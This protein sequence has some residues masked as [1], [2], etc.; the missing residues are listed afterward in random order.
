MSVKFFRC[1]LLIVSLF[2]IPVAYAVDIRIDYSLDDNGFFGDPS[3]PDDGFKER[4]DAIEAVAAFFSE[5]LTDNLLAIDPSDF[6]GASWTPQLFHPATGFLTNLQTDLVIPEDEIVIFVGGRGLGGSGIGGPGGFS[7]ANGS[8]EWFARILGRGDQN[9]DSFTDSENSDVAPWGG[10]ISFSTTLNWNFSLTENLGGFEFVSTAIHE[11]CHVLGIGTADSW[12]NLITS[13]DLF[14]GEAVTRSFGANT[15]VQSANGNGGHG[16]FED[17]SQILMS[18][19]YGS[20]G[21]THGTIQRV[22]MIPSGLDTGRNFRVLSDLDLAALIDIGWEVQVPTTIEELTFSA[23]S[24]A[25]VRWPSSSF[26]DYQVTRSSNLDSDFVN[27]G[28]LQAGNGNILSWEDPT[29]P[30]DRAF[31]RI[32]ASSVFPSTGSGPLSA[33]TSFKAAIP[34]EDFLTIKGKIVYPIECGCETPF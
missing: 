1:S 22:A 28:P 18:D 23:S 10:S 7:T 34:S 21:A 4:R 26:I 27:Q 5:I 16:H 29:T 17:T 8:P 31:Y 12:E 2:C 32:S 14:T 15:P 13:S 3:D 19:S 20:F 33:F 30:T 24:L 9:A 25:V 6:P 11:L